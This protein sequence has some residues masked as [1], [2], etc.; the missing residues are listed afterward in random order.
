VRTATCPVHQRLYPVPCPGV[1]RSTKAPASWSAVVR[2][3]ELWGPTMP[4]SLTVSS[5]STGA[6]PPYDSIS[7]ILT[8]GR[9]CRGCDL[10]AASVAPRSR[11]CARALPANVVPGVL[12]ARST[13]SGDARP[14]FRRA[15]H[16]VSA[17]AHGL[18]A[19][20]VGSVREGMPRALDDV[21]CSTLGRSSCGA[22]RGEW[23][24]WMGCVC[25]IWSGRVTSG[26]SQ[27]AKW[28][29]VWRVSGGVSE[30]HASVA[31]G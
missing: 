14:L 20:D 2:R 6:N 28:C 8:S 12:V 27:T 19:Q 24:T 29:G 10:P 22:A 16:R 30:A 23:I 9:P 13:L 1:W 21:A 18:C 4:S 7:A 17:D 11:A 3:A 5:A 25:C 31:G 26:T 15:C